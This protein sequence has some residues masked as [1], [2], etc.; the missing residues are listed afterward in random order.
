MIYMSSFRNKIDLIFSKRAI[1][2]A[3]LFFCFYKSFY[4]GWGNSL[5][6]Y[7]LFGYSLIWVIY[8]FASNI[9][10]S[11]RVNMMFSYA[12]FFTLIISL[13][14]NG[15]DDYKFV[16]TNIV[17]YFINLFVYLHVDYEQNTDGIF[18]DLKLYLIIYI[19]LCSLVSIINIIYRYYLIV[20]GDLILFGRESGIFQHPNYAGWYSSICLICIAFMIK[21]F[22]SRK[23]VR[24]AL[25]IL[26]CF[27]CYCLL[28][29]QCRSGIFAVSIMFPF[30]LNGLNLYDRKVFNSRN[31]IIYYS[32]LL[33]FAIVAFLRRGFSGRVL[34]YEFALNEFMKYNKII[35]V[36]YGKVI[37]IWNNDFN[38]ILLKTDRYE[39]I[40]TYITVFNTHNNFIHELC[41]HGIIGFLLY[42][43]YN[44][45]IIKIILNVNRI[46][47]KLDKKLRFSFLL[48][49]S[50][51]VLTFIIGLFDDCVLSNIIIYVNLFNLISASYLILIFGKYYE[52]LFTYLLPI[53]K[54]VL[55]IFDFLSSS[56][57]VG[58][59]MVSFC[60]MKNTFLIR[61]TKIL[62]Y[63]VCSYMLL[64]LAYRI[65][66]KFKN[67]FSRDYI[68]PFYMIVSVV[69]SSIINNSLFER[70]NVMIFCMFLIYLFVLPQRDISMTYNKIEFDYDVILILFLLFSF[71]YTSSSLIRSY[72]MGNIVRPFGINNDY[73]S[74][75]RITMFSSAISLYFYHK[76]SDRIKKCVYIIA[77]AF[78]FAIFLIIQQRAAY[79]AFAVGVVICMICIFFLDKKIF[80]KLKSRNILTILIIICSTFALIHFVFHYDFSHITKK[81]ISR[82]MSGRDTI[83]SCGFKS[84][85]MH[86]NYIFGAS[87]ALLSKQWTECVNLYPEIYSVN[88]IG[89]YINRLVREAATHSSYFEQLFAHGIIGFALLNFNYL[90]IV[91][92]LIK[93]ITLCKKTYSIQNFSSYLLVLFICVT[94]LFFS[95]FDRSILFDFVFPINP[96]FFISVGQ[97]FCMSNIM[98][99]VN[100]VGNNSYV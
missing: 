65:L 55:F 71:V 85:R 93:Y 60:F 11:F 54:L 5:F 46:K 50:L 28:I 45:F 30:V 78:F 7:S 67:Y 42:F 56:I 99:N 52:S 97:L 35:G 74:F 91:F 10:N 39:S 37:K 95:V 61:N 9:K 70:V 25:I 100:L 14:F 51:F 3:S 83:L 6:T 31:I 84:M 66:F 77:S 73:I 86:N 57:V 1:I 96:L 44:V 90:Y 22:Y 72:L 88:V 17:I 87:E 4:F 62:S 68:I 63:I 69:I 2:V 13:L 43:I 36:G 41:V 26:F 82:T 24:I 32:I 21:N 92:K 59:V 20:I 27:H 19:V 80:L 18:E 38:S 79:V 81:L 76:C 64:V 75:S 29:S 89:E 23:N 58:I 48:V 53:Y 34:I 47:E 15:V 98:N 16:L 94:S 49:S 12:I 33:A 40:F 8:N